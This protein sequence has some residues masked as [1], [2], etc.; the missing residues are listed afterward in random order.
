MCLNIRKQTQL[1]N[2]K[3]TK[4]KKTIKTYAVLSLFLVGFTLPSSAQ[5]KKRTTTTT[6]KTV[7][8]KVPGK[9]S[10]KKVEYSNKKKKVVSVRTIPNKTVVKHNGEDYFYS[11]NKFYAYSRGSYIPIAPKNGFKIKSLPAGSN[12][13]RFNN[14]TYFTYAG[15]FYIQ[16]GSNYEVVEPEIGT[17]VYELPN[18]AEKVKIDGESYYEYANILYQKIKISGSKAYEIVGIVDIQ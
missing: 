17:I 11:N 10:S 4:M 7:T 16:V 15:I 9:I 18:D 14:K 13:V 8:K 3:I 2:L 1:L 6:T 5:A 12:K